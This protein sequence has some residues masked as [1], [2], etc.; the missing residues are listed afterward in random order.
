MAD[1]P[2]DVWIRT[3]KRANESTRD[4][5]ER[6]GDEQ[7]VTR[8]GRRFLK[9]HY[10]Q[11][12]DEE[13]RA[14]QLAQPPPE[15]PE[16][17]EGKVPLNLAQ[18]IDPETGKLDVQ[19]LD[20]S[21]RRF[22]QQFKK[23]IG[24]QMSVLG[25]Q[26]TGIEWSQEAEDRLRQIA[27]PSTTE[28]IQ[29]EGGF[30]GWAYDNLPK[31]WLPPGQLVEQTGASA[32]MYGLSVPM[33]MATGPIGGT[34]TAYAL[35]N[36]Q[37]AGET[38]DRILEDPVVRRL[39]QMPEGRYIDLDP[40]HQKGLKEF[41]LEVGRSAG[42][43]RMYTSGL[44]ELPALWFP[45]FK[46]NK[47]IP[48]FIKRQALDVTF[49]SISE[50]VDE[51]LYA[52]GVAKAFEEKGMSPEDADKLQEEVR[53]M[54]PERWEIF[55]SA[56]SQELTMGSVGTGAEVVASKIM[57][58]N[59]D[60][61]V[62]DTKTNENELHETITHRQ[63]ELLPQYE[64]EVADQ[65]RKDADEEIKDKKEQDR[66][67]NARLDFLIKL[68]QLKQQ[69]EKA[70]REG[71]DAEEAHLQ[72]MIDQEELFAKNLPK[73]LPLVDQ[74]RIYARKKA[75]LVK[76]GWDPKSIYMDNDGEARIKI[77]ADLE[78]LDIE[79]DR[80]TGEPKEKKGPVDLTLPKPGEKIIAYK[81]GEP[82]TVEV[83]SV[84][85]D[86]RVTIL[87]PPVKDK[88]G[89]FKS[90]ESSILDEG[91]YSSTFLSSLEG[92]KSHPVEEPAPAPTKRPYSEYSIT[93]L[94][95]E[96]TQIE[97]ETPSQF[98]SQN[99]ALQEVNAEIAE[100][101]RRMLKEEPADKFERERDQISYSEQEPDVD[102][103]NLADEG[104]SLVDAADKYN[105]NL[106]TE[107]PANFSNPV[108]KKVLNGILSNFEKLKLKKIKFDVKDRNHVYK[109]KLDELRRKNP[110]ADPD[111]IHA[112]ATLR[113][114]RGGAYVDNKPD[115]DVNQSVVLISD[116]IRGK[117]SE[118][119][120]RIAVQ[121]LWHELFGHKALRDNFGGINDKKYK[122][123]I[124]EFDKNNGR[125][126]DDWLRTGGVTGGSAYAN[127]PRFRQVEEF[128]ARNFAEFGISKEGKFRKLI[129]PIRE[130]LRS[131]GFSTIREQDLISI[132][133]KLQDEY[134]PNNRSI[135]S[136]KPLTTTRPV[137]PEEEETVQEETTPAD[138]PEVSESRRPS[139]FDRF[140]SLGGRPPLGG[141]KAAKNL[142][143]TGRDAERFVDN[144][145]R[146]AIAGNS[147]PTELVEDLIKFDRLKP[148]YAEGLKKS[149]KSG[150]GKAEK[151]LA[152]TVLASGRE[153]YLKRKRGSW[154][155][156]DLHEM[157]KSPKGY[158]WRTGPE[159]KALK[160][161]R[162]DDAEMQMARRQDQARKGDDIS[163]S[164]RVSARPVDEQ[165]L[166][167]GDPMPSW[168]WSLFQQRIPNPEEYTEN[169]L[170]Q[171]AVAKA[172][173][174]GV[175]RGQTSKLL[176]EKKKP[177][178]RPTKV[179][180]EIDALGHRE[181]KRIKV[182]VKDYEQFVKRHKAWQKVMLPALEKLKRSGYMSPDRMKV[183][184]KVAQEYEDLISESR[185]YVEDKYGVDLPPR[186]IMV[187]P[188]KALPSS[189]EREEGK[190][191][192]Q[193]VDRGM[194]SEDAPSYRA[195]GRYIDVSDGM[196]ASS[197]Q[198]D[199]TGTTV[200]YAE[201]DTNFPGNRASFN[202]SG[203]DSQRTI[204]DNKPPGK[205]RITGSRIST[206]AVISSNLIGQGQAKFLDAD[207]GVRTDTKNIATLQN[208]GIRKFNE[209]NGLQE[210]PK[211]NYS[212]HLFAS[213][214]VYDTDVELSTTG[215]DR[216]PSL[217]PK[218]YGDIIV[219]DQIATVEIGGRQ[220]PLYDRL[221]VVPPNK[222][223]VSYS[224]VGEIGLREYAKRNGT[225]PRAAQL[226]SDLARQKKGDKKGA[227]FNPG[228]RDDKWRTEV[229]NTG[230]KVKEWWRR[231]WQMPFTYNG[232]RGDYDVAID[233]KLE[234]R[235]QSVAEKN[236]ETGEVKIKKSK[237]ALPWM[238]LGDFLDL[239]VLSDYY[240]QLDTTIIHFDKEDG[241][242]TAYTNHHDNVDSTPGE[243]SITVGVAPPDKQTLTNLDPSN[244]D[245]ST[246]AWVEDIHMKEMNDP[247]HDGVPH[248]LIATILHEL[249][250][251]IQGIEGFET[252]GRT[253]EMMHRVTEDR[254]AKIIRSS[255]LGIW[256]SIDPNARLK[257][258]KRFGKLLKDRHGEKAAKKM[259]NK[260]GLKTPYTGSKWSKGH[261]FLSDNPIETL[262]RWGK[263]TRLEMMDVFFDAD[264]AR[265][266][267]FKE[268]FD[269]PVKAL[270][271]AAMQLARDKQIKAKDALKLKRLLVNMME[272][273]EM[274]ALGT[275]AGPDPIYIE[276]K[277]HLTDDR[278]K[279]SL[280]QS[281]YLKLIGEV[282]ARDVQNRYIDMFRGNGRSGLPALLDKRKRNL[283]M[284]QEG[285]PFL[286]GGTE[287][288]V[289]RILRGGTGAMPINVPGE[290]PV[291]APWDV[292]DMVSYSMNDA[293][294]DFANRLDIVTRAR[295]AQ[296]ENLPKD[297]PERREAIRQLHMGMILN[298]IP[299]KDPTKPLPYQDEV[300]ESS[301]AYEDLSWSQRL[302]GHESSGSDL[303]E[304]Y[305]KDPVGYNRI[306]NAK[307]GYI[308]TASAGRGGKAQ[309][310]GLGLKTIVDL[311]QKKGE[312]KGEPG[313]DAWKH[314]M[315]VQGMADYR[316][317]SDR[318]A[319]LLY[320]GKIW[321]TWQQ[322]R[323][324]FGLGEGGRGRDAVPY[325]G[326]IIKFMK[327]QREKLMTGQ[328]TPRDIAKTSVMT[329]VS[330]GADATNPWTV[331]NFTGGTRKVPPRYTN[332]GE[333]DR[334]E[335]IR[336][337]EAG[338]WEST[339]KLNPTLENYTDY[340]NGEKEW[341]QLGKSNRGRA[342]V[343]GSRT[344]E[345]IAEF[346]NKAPLWVVNIA[347]D[348]VGPNGDMQYK[349][350]AD[351]KN[352]PKTVSWEEAKELGKYP[353]KN[354]P[355]LVKVDNQWMLQVDGENYTGII[356]YKKIK[357]VEKTNN[358]GKIAEKETKIEELKTSTYQAEQKQEAIDKLNKNKA[359]LKRLELALEDEFA[360]LTPEYDKKTG[361]KLKKAFTPPVIAELKTKIETKTIPDTKK[362]IKAAE[363]EI[364]KRERIR[365]EELE[366]IVKRQEEIKELKETIKSDT[367]I[368]KTNKKR[369]LE[370][371]PLWWK[372]PGKQKAPGVETGGVWVPQ[373]YA[374][375]GGRPRM[376]DAVAYFFSTDE[377]QK[378]LDSIEGVDGGKPR[379]ELALWRRIADI[380]M[381]YGDDRLANLFDEGEYNKAGEITKAS[382]KN[383]GEFTDQL[384]SI[385]KR[386]IEESGMDAKTL[387]S[388][389]PKAVEKRFALAAEI[390]DFAQK[391][392]S[393][394]GA[395]QAF[396]KHFLGLG[397]APTIDAIELNTNIAGSPATDLAIS[398]LTGKPVAGTWRVDLKWW[399]LKIDSTKLSSVDAIDAKGKEGTFF[400]FYRDKIKKAF[401]D[402]KIDVDK[403]DPS[404]FADVPA[405]YFYHIMH[406]W[407]WDVGKALTRADAVM[408]ESTE[409]YRPAAYEA[410]R[411]DAN[412]QVF[413]YFLKDHIEAEMV[414]WSQHGTIDAAF[415]MSE[416]D[417]KALEDSAIS[418]SVNLQ[419]LVGQFMQRSIADR[420]ATGFY[421][422]KDQNSTIWPDKHNGKVG[423][424][425][426]G[427][428]G[429]PLLDENMR[430]IRGA[431]PTKGQRKGR[432]A[433]ASNNSRITKQARDLQAQGANHILTVI[434]ADDMHFSNK[435]YWSI[436][437]RETA[438]LMRVNPIVLSRINNEV[439]TIL[440]GTISKGLIPTRTLLRNEKIN[441]PSL[442]NWE[443]LLK[444]APQLS[445]QNRKP[446]INLFGG[447]FEIKS[448]K[449]IGYSNK[450]LWKD[451]T[452]FKRAP[453]YLPVGIIKLDPVGNQFNKMTHTDIGV[454]EHE[455]YPYV[456]QGELIASFIDTFDNPVINKPIADFKTIFSD[457]EQV[458]HT[459]KNY[460]P[461]IPFRLDE[462]WDAKTGKWVKSV[463]NFRNVKAA[464]KLP[465]AVI[466]NFEQHMDAPAT[467]VS[468]SQ[469][470][471]NTA[472]NPVVIQDLETARQKQAEW[473]V[474]HSLWDEGKPKL[475]S[476][477]L[478]RNLELPLGRKLSGFVTRFMEPFG[479]VDEPGLLRTIRRVARGKILRIE[480]VSSKIYK[481]L[482]KTK[483]SKA[484]YEY[485]TQ[486]GGDLSKLESLGVPLKERMYAKEAKLAIVEIGKMLV[487]AG[488]MHESALKRHKDSYLPRI[489]LQYLLD[490]NDIYAIQR[491]LSNRVSNMDYLKKRKGV[492]EY[493]EKLL[494]G[495]VKD[496]AFLAGKMLIQPARDVALLDMF[497]EI[498][499]TSKDRG[500]NWVLPDS[501]IEFDFLGE[502][503]KAAKDKAIGAS[504]ADELAKLPQE[505][506]AIETEIK[507]LDQ[508]IRDE[509][510]V[511]RAK[512]RMMS[513]ELKDLL[514]LRGSLQDRLKILK[515]RSMSG[516]A[517]KKE[518][519]RLIKVIWPNLQ[520][521]HPGEA[522]VV[523]DLASAMNEKADTVINRVEA[524]IPKDYK[525]IP[526]NARY[527]K[528]RGLI[529]Q[530]EIY[531]DLVGS[532]KMTKPT[533]AAEAI[534]GEGGLLGKAGRTFKWSKVAANFPAAWIRNFT[535][536]TIAMNLGG[537]PMGKIP[538]FL[539]KAS[540]SIIDTWIEDFRENSAKSKGQPYTRKRTV[541]DEVKDLGLTSSTFATVE[542]GVI[543][544]DYE[545]FL[546]RTQRKGSP[547]R[548]FF[549]VKEF[550]NMAKDWTS[551]KYGM[552]D[553]LGKTMMYMNGIDQ[554]MSPAQAADE[555][556][557]WLFDYS[558]VKPSV[559]TLRKDVLG[560][561]FITYASKVFPLMVETIST[562]PW[563]LAPYVAL[564]Y[565]MA[566]LFKSEHDLDDD[567]YYA[568]IESLQEYLREKKYAGN[569]M[570]LIY[571]DEHGRP[572]ILDL[573]YLYPWGMFSEMASEL[574]SDDPLAVIQTIG[575]MTGVGPTVIA[576]VTTGVDPF[577]RRP[578]VNK[579]DDKTEQM[580]Q[581]LQYTWNLMMPPWAHTE[582]G[583]V[584]RLKQTLE[585]ELNRYGEPQKTVSQAISQG[586]GFNVTPVEPHGQRIKNLRWMQSEV[587]KTQSFAKR[588][589]RDMKAKGSTKEELKKKKEYFLEVIKDR[590]DKLMDY[591]K[592][593]KFPKSKFPPL[594][595]AG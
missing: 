491:G 546:N 226:A 187:L 249:Q 363:E 59:R 41:A 385:I 177:K 551:D 293:L 392:A 407:L 239:G 137:Q 350:L 517:L 278:F 35:S 121:Q 127:D 186:K 311:R 318:A 116:N 399:A 195:G 339:K 559:K 208:E 503:K 370:G 374:T 221:I 94:Q 454:P 436:W 205:P 118:E 477:P 327:L 251:V 367:R 466:S 182:S 570:P 511:L 384:N 80:V 513:K 103:E 66:A 106:D 526:D 25:F 442:S 306:R 344:P 136:G 259:L 418:E 266:R 435:A 125:D 449:A 325:L 156:R 247:D 199:M 42:L 260:F 236:L 29:E 519:D 549:K 346:Y 90:R 210:T 297:S 220:A 463:Y 369:Y 405:D 276:G 473:A 120:I 387:Q 152:D 160:K 252:G 412:Q 386:H 524:I 566:A 556:E 218:A 124:N 131:M 223:E 75:A 257:I 96:K 132:F 169:S 588:T 5:I 104:E 289:T 273:F 140:V 313:Y 316:E 74:Q 480:E 578:I 263:S 38:H 533:N 535:S 58:K 534:L 176:P 315:L 28:Q 18:D 65:A 322:I 185:S 112:E 356:D 457:L 34:A 303:G 393:I 408:G 499:V 91:K 395:K 4:A 543:E 575:L 413:D 280:G 560:A 153:G 583:A 574:M 170:L 51:D 111:F 474:S 9:G 216:S 241:Y 557:K 21:W 532:L 105:D 200:P 472:N 296:I 148:E 114:R 117:N 17:P 541:Y 422:A 274:N 250:H 97:K 37:V 163:E 294:G 126:V 123:I 47:L 569:I 113:S 171:D 254:M 455:A 46:I 248:R 283:V 494:K 109:V 362:K 437:W 447:V 558:L 373:E 193:W 62:D 84:D 555:A 453:M 347:W 317:M 469:A 224:Y 456:V 590:Y 490:E 329:N 173:G 337:K 486:E 540:R 404:I 19:S 271:D 334:N 446:L 39:M 45:A 467:P 40:T 194:I 133:E 228:A 581:I 468:F 476:K 100:R 174:T 438:D 135:I 26:D 565:A 321:T 295:I 481:A 497:E 211:G 265:K 87:E 434:G 3:N 512:D 204:K 314:R 69:R 338:E 79:P 189:R 212:D 147:W 184:E 372:D 130:K 548:A 183:D 222:N 364:K 470:I 165:L 180:K 488:L 383:I 509:R 550:L 510:K 460:T 529:V 290:K 157:A 424:W 341:V 77:G 458:I 233:F 506:D 416:A 128:I 161:M 230:V 92:Y 489:Y 30:L 12:I 498:I 73:V 587:I 277:P 366:R 547:F 36:L 544:K 13:D 145:L 381:A 98:H 410:M 563:R 420:F 330:Q 301:V 542:L 505:R 371:L 255:T 197:S 196:P 483:H 209:Q 237:E 572:Q 238:R 417:A 471:Q 564:P 71:R 553:S 340:M 304:R 52:Y 181:P 571:L 229:P 402:I 57:G 48:E 530:R 158:E 561:P 281:D 139:D 198:P 60:Y 351:G 501:L 107:S 516:W 427:G 328:M 232:W 333:I 562:R 419:G 43:R 149:L 342:E 151:R 168:D 213:Q 122:D 264:S 349:E 514:S 298:P 286:A 585:G 428:I 377:G 500:L 441:N 482:K 31:G 262:K 495:L 528:L 275:R 567:E 580:K 368:I 284:G 409:R 568:M 452:I 178:G 115:A 332:K 27:P 478:D 67:D 378:A 496:P 207:P 172:F 431:K 11:Q 531:D 382:L 33:Y 515:P 411:R 522:K 343:Y 430:G 406:H 72:R 376:E 86:G 267:K 253:A 375:T 324:M 119:V 270:D 401:D 426:R 215:E 538:Y 54:G 162:P 138:E 93:E 527:G 353:G 78:G 134:I 61:R 234:T 502:I 16:Q 192:Q 23:S 190:V 55:W 445:F 191:F 24:S 576:G 245:M 421:E 507:D 335:I 108:L 394:A 22:G 552:I 8:S 291:G 423:Y 2:F 81:D 579:L 360:G 400:D 523:L 110:D 70:E 242:G 32:P 166:P 227:W 203:V 154:R 268:L 307:G 361:T 358:P 348:G 493:A 595:K 155:D 504:L 258:Q 536:N 175:R 389:D 300:S 201:I 287:R 143:K 396:W 141:T 444:V 414:S 217:K 240:P 508:A 142:K 403:R 492:P 326:H 323:D 355:Q 144:A 261:L 586:M 439:N 146:K 518:A 398:P 390:G 164:S 64:K 44:I 231:G 432:A 150:M 462:R 50:V 272:P 95:S 573:A 68:D 7:A 1:I 102:T 379:F 593:S 292:N 537:M 425:M 594:R 15:M 429:Y 202:V 14:K 89:R 312:K 302:P 443:L 305:I 225:D 99:V 359:L 6:Y 433:W 53:A 299:I 320:E 179:Q 20:D 591:K 459:L 450:E 88:R 397:D 243:T 464:Y 159:W 310:S 520:E 582:Y 285:P 256:A 388:D 380:R 331:L 188:P 63:E 235:K 465:G 282:E 76:Q 592:R 101:D 219:G 475:F 246:E 345:E 352:F 167:S 206:G 440:F 279:E 461:Q 85:S 308:K 129:S 244:M 485:L 415:E 357:A 539:T 82:E 10:S 336:L 269:E 391:M 354:A 484:I 589:L 448:D 525:K 49:G 56:F 288:G 83:E 451:T 545:N 309:Y 554:G 365:D 479:K 584:S 577:T 214:V 487:R 319:K 521:E